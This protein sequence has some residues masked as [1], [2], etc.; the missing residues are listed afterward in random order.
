MELN[1]YAAILAVIVAMVVEAIVFVRKKK[2]LL[3]SMGVFLLTAYF[4]VVAIITLFP[5]PLYVYP[6]QNP[7]DMG[8]NLVPFLSIFDSF[9]VEDAPSWY[10]QSLVVIYAGNFLMLSPE[11]F[12]LP[13]LF[14]RCK[15]PKVALSVVLLTTL[16]IEGLQLVIGLHA[17]YLYRCVDI[18]DVILN[19]IG[20]ALGFCLAQAVMRVRRRSE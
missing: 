18:D 4:G 15:S 8:Y 12:L 10:M 19:F 11:G 3:W 14:P 20:G 6:E 16:C 17:G 13:L 7:V 2:G 5:I 9:A 1:S